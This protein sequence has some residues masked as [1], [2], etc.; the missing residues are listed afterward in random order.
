MT[1]ALTHAIT[2]EAQAAEERR[3]ARRRWNGAFAGIGILAALA[4]GGWWG[5]QNL[6]V[7]AIQVLA[8]LPASNMTR[9]PEQ[10]HWVDGVH[11]AL[12]TELQRAG[13][14]VI[15]RQSV[16]QYRETDKPVRQIASE[17][18]VD[19]LIQPVV[20]REGDSVVVDVSILEANSELPIF[21]QTFASRV[22]GVLG[23]YRAVSAEIADAIGA[24]LSEEAEA[25]LAERPQVDPRVIEYVLLGESHLGRF[26]PEDFDI[27]LNY[28]QAAL[29]IDSL[30]APAYDG[31]GGVWGFRAQMGLVDP[32]EAGRNAIPYAEK[33]L[34]LD[35]GNAEL[36][37][38][39]AS[40]IFW[41]DWDYERA[42]EEAVRCLELDPNAAGAR[43]FY[44]HML[45]IM[46]RPDEARR[47]GERAVQLDPMNSF[48]L[49]LHGAILAFTAPPEE[50]I[51]YLES[52]F[53]DFP[54]AGFGYVPLAMAYRRAGLEDEETRAYRADMAVSGFDW[55]VAALDRGME[56][57]GNREARRQAAEAMADRFEEAYLPT[58]NIARFYR[59]AGEVEKALDWLERSLEYHDPNLPYIGVTGWED[60]YD[61]PRFQAVAEEVG[62]PLLTW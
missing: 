42:M 6:T 51:Q 21:T 15:A 31:V 50:A 25:R 44:G 47:Q 17:L 53:E 23:L 7:P 22:Q 60:L 4:L 5:W 16:L 19:A 59:D 28:F 32:L 54:G 35:P 48:V 2:A 9:D 52:M 58:E 62:V 29:A 18:G 41:H 24:V 56:E 43:A 55:V 8:V 27:A 36:R 30:Y 11:E 12:V 13:I 14:A 45:M 20:G 46:G 3:A 26:T 49:G 1:D 33:A 10:D 34:E 40:S 39:Q 61:H 37:C 57:G 38:G